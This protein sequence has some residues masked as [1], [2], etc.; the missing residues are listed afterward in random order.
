MRAAQKGLESC[1]ERIGWSL[2]RTARR[3]FS[4][5]HSSILL[6]GFQRIYALLKD[7]TQPVPASGFIGGSSLE[8]LCS[9]SFPTASNQVMSP[10]A[11]FEL[12]DGDHSE[13]QDTIENSITKNALHQ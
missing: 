11:S 10:S 5:K 9:F 12:F 6:E 8:F 4:A 2:K 13:F 7:L 1:P 3:L